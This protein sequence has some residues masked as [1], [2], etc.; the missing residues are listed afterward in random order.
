MTEL[1][2]TTSNLESST[3][4]NTPHN[5]KT[6]PNQNTRPKSK[7]ATGD[8]FQTIL[9][10]LE[11]AFCTVVVGITASHLHN[12]RNEPAWSKKRFIYT[13]VV[14]AL[15]LLVSLLLLLPW[16]WHYVTWPLDFIMFALFMIAFGLLADVCVA[17]SPSVFL[18]P[19]LSST[20]VFPSFDDNDGDGMMTRNG[21]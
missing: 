13:E 5:Q 14:A 11:L 20:H 6:T 21:I 2:P 12:V 8:L 4:T 19:I 15:G 7:M 17:Y 9:R 1:Q 10:F 18:S 16:T 3:T